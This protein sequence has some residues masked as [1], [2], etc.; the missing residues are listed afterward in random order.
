[1]K[2]FLQKYKMFVADGQ[3]VQIPKNR[4]LSFFL[5]FFHG[6]ITTFDVSSNQ[7]KAPHTG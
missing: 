1:M 4:L 3:Y 7:G 2:D 6:F 5:S